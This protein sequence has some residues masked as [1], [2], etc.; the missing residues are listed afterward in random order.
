MIWVLLSSVTQSST[1]SQ[2]SAPGMFLF[3]FVYHPVVVVSWMLLALLWVELTLQVTLL[4]LIIIYE[5]LCWGY[6]LRQSC[7][8]QCLVIAEILLWVCRLAVFVNLW[9][10][11]KSTTGCVGSGSTWLGSRYSLMSDVG[12][13]SLGL[14]VWSYYTNHCLWLYLL[15]LDVCGRG[16]SL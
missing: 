7:S 5:L 9:Y 6:P 11:L 16:Q 12:I 14:P 1:L 8:W 10:G 15:H 13:I 3:G 4:I 2:L